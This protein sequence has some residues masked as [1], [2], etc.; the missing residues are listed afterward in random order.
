MGAG[1]T[2]IDL[3][4]DYAQGFNANYTGRSRTGDGHAAQRGR[5]QGESPGRTR[6][7]I[8]AKGL[9]KVGDSFVNEAY[10]ESDVTKVN[11]DVQGGVGEINLEV[12]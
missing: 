11:V 3:T 5:G 9:E 10:G 4:G 1:K 7:K 8:D 12:V 6:S 2:T